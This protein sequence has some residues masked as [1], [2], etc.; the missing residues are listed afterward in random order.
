M[1]NHR[2]IREG[3][4]CSRK[5]RKESKGSQV[6]TWLTEPLIAM[7]QSQVYDIPIAKETRTLEAYVFT[8]CALIHDL[9]GSNYGIIRYF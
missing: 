9:Q 4:V 7:I 3:D 1:C 6:P 2:E 5:G 8:K